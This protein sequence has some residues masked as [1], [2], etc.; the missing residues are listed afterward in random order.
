MGIKEKI[1]NIKNIR[2]QE[3]E[4]PVESLYTAGIAGERFFQKLKE[5][6]FLAT[7]CPECD[8]TFLPPKIYC[9]FC[10]HPLTEWRKIENEASLVS[11][12]ILHLGPNGEELKCPEV[13]GLINMKGTD[14]FFIHRVKASCQLEPGLLME[15]VF[16]K[17]NERE[18]NINDILYFQPKV[19]RGKRQKKK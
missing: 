3:G 11:Y 10:F 16:K 6:V 9:E 15:A 7:Y 14:T 4:L 17:K 2:T 12:T 1:N 5:E 18:G 19:S 8:F 13:V